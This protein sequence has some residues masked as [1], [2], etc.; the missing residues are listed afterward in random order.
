VSTIHLALEA[1]QA[2]DHVRAR[3]VCVELAEQGQIHARYLLGVMTSFGE[4]G[5]ADSAEAA[6]HYR[7]AAEAGHPVAAYCL[8]ALHAL[9]RGVEQDYTQALLWYRRAAE[10]GDPDALFKIGVMYANGEGVEKDLPEAIRWWRQAA[11]RAQSDAMVFLGHASR[12]GNGVE[13]D[14]V[15]AAEWYLKAWQAED[16]DAAPFLASLEEDLIAAADAGSLRAQIT[17]G[18]FY[19]SIHKDPLKAVWR[20]AQAA[21][22]DHPEALRLLA[23]C[24]QEGAGV[25]RSEVRATALYRKAAEHGDRFAQM[26]L[27]ER[28]AKGLDGL[29]EDTDEA[30]RWY[31]RAANQGVMDAQRPLAELLARRN[32][33]HRDANEA[34][35]RLVLAARLGPPDAEYQLRAGD[36]T[37]S[38]YISKSGTEVAFKPLALEELRG[39][40]DDHEPPAPGIRVPTVEESAVKLLQQLIAARRDP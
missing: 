17:L 11:E 4:G 8:A 27:A 22:Q 6:R 16:R 35:Q 14:P 21:D 12:R 20:L 3:K 13:R 33:D 30:I 9:G 28:L 32:R 40:P 36:D 29:K 39:L 19:K 1:Y 10:G 25:D 38:A 24:Y 31:R 5:P 2:R 26:Y 7:V 37:W 34:F 18:I 15:A 23:V